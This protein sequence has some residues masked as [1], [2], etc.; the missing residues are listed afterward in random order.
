MEKTR[1]RQT[2]GDINLR[3]RGEGC[4]FDWPPPQGKLGQTTH[5]TQQPLLVLPRSAESP[6]QAYLP[7][8]TAGIKSDPDANTAQMS[9]DPAERDRC[10]VAATASTVLLT[11]SVSSSSLS[12]ARDVEQESRGRGNTT[13]SSSLTNE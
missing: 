8:S 4:P 12:R 10:D 2:Q 1:P 3:G 5:V 11:P 7:R 13:L 9:L 6:A